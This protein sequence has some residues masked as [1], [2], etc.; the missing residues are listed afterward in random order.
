MQVMLSGP[1]PA[2]ASAI[3]SLAAW[4]GSV[5]SAQHAGDRL[6]VRDA[7]QPAGAQQV[8]GFAQLKIGLEVAVG[9]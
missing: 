9:L 3:R 6:G 7:V 5:T 2:M 1:P 4:S 8:P